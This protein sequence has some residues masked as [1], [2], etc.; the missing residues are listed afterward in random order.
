MLAEKTLPCSCKGPSASMTREAV[1]PE[2]VKTD[3]LSA[4]LPA[5]CTDTGDTVV[6]ALIKQNWQAIEAGHLNRLH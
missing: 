5:K 4:M 1:Q 2:S 6:M 3:Q